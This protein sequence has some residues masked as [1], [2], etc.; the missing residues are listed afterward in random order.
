MSTDLIPESFP[1][2]ATEILPR[3][4]NFFK[5]LNNDGSL[6]ILLY[7]SNN[8]VQPG[9]F[10]SQPSTSNTF[11]SISAPFSVTLYPGKQKYVTYSDGIWS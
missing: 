9:S 11:G 5:V 2:G 8:S 10:V 1:V 3:G 6:N 7:F 4:S